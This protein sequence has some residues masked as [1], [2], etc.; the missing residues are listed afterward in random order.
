VK[1]TK[2]P[3]KVDKSSKHN[4]LITQKPNFT[5]VEYEN[6]YN[7]E[8]RLLCLEKLGEE[9]VEYVLNNNKCFSIENFLRFKHIYHDDYYGWLDISKPLKQS[10]EHAKIIIADRLNSGAYTREYD[11]AHVRW[12]LPRFG[13][14]WEDLHKLHA[15]LKQIAD[16][17]NMSREE[18]VN[19]IADA[20]KP[21]ES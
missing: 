10:H 4:T 6:A 15:S 16:Q 20:L 19:K 21:Y 14:E 8:M 1:K 3:R 9:L 5:T 2:K 13:K 7:R 17:N 12:N 18:L 11:G